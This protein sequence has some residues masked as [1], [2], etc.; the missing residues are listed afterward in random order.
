MRDRG[1]TEEALRLIT[2][3][4]DFSGPSSTLISTRAV[5][6]IRAGKL[7]QA[8]DELT[9]AKLTAPDSSSLALHLAWRSG[10]KAGTG[11]SQR[12]PRG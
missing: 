4:I 8:V 3:A 11:C 9:K 2:R 12:V 10:P 5:I 6:L 1:Q 7:D